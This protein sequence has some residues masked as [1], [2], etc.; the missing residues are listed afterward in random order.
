MGKL[1]LR[2]IKSYD[3]CHIPAWW[4]GQNWSPGSLSRTNN[5]LDH[6]AN[7]GIQGLVL[8]QTFP[9][10][11]GQLPEPRE[12]VNRPLPVEPGYFTTLL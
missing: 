11:W 7:A 6:P 2:E 10:A 4:Q 8:L 3:K 5:I 9:S 12:S 1:R